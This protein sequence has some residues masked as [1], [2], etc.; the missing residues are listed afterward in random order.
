MVLAN[1]WKVNEVLS[2]CRLQTMTCASVPVALRGEEDGA[3][4]HHHLKQADDDEMV[5]RIDV[6]IAAM[7]VVDIVTTATE[8]NEMTGTSATTAMTGT[9]ATIVIAVTVTDSMTEIAIIIGEKATRIIATESTA[10]RGQ[11]GTEMVAEV[12]GD[13]MV[14]WLSCV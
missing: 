8:M 12:V 13:V 9:N 5:Q 11:S 2:L 6:T 14:R 4:A 10:T 7:M 1:A 3:G